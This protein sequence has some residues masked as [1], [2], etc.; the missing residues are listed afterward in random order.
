MQLLH[1]LRQWDQASAARPDLLVANSGY[2]AERI[3]KCW[4]REA[5][6]IHPPVATQRFTLQ[7]N[8]QE[9]FL[10]ASRMVPYK[11]VELVA[12]AFAAM[13]QH[14]LVICG[15][16]PSLPL[17]QAA[18]RGAA[19]I[20][21]RGRVPGP[22][23]VALTQGARACVFAAEEDFGIATVEAQACG[24]P[25]LAFG[26]GGAADIVLPGETG[27]LF[28]EQSAAAIRAAVERFADS[29]ISPEACRANAERFSEAAFRAA[30]RAAAEGGKA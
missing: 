29:A 21:L 3:L 17:V 23:L 30:F 4:R 12:E 25:V 5:R 11:R 8:K 7:T 14:R 18:A 1:R 20:E 15:D 26:K 24:T 10:I 2:I 16:G 27:F 9:Y 6:V 19:N 13:P 28:A 22:E